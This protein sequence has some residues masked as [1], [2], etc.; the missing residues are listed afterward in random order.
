M[1]AIARLAA[2][3]L[4]APVAVLA[5]AEGTNAPEIASNRVDGNGRNGDCYECSVSGNGQVVVFRSNTDNLVPM[6]NE[7][8]LDRI[9]LGDLGAGTMALVSQSAGIQFN[10]G[11]YNPQVSSNGRFVLFQTYTAGLVEP[12]N[13]GTSDLYLLDRKKGTLRVVSLDGDGNVGNSDSFMDGAALSANG[14]FVAFYSTSSNFVDGVGNGN[15]QAFLLDVK[16]GRISLASRNDAGEPADNGVQRVSISAN[17][18]WLSFVSDASNLGVMN[19]NSDNQIFAYDA[20]RKRTTLASRNLMGFVGNQSS[21]SSVIANNGV[22]AFLSYASDIGSGNMDDG[23]QDAFVF[24]P[25]KGGSITAIS[26][27]TGG[28]DAQGSANGV[29]ISQNGK[30]V[31]FST[32]QNLVA[33]DPNENYDVYAA[34]LPFVAP[35]LISR[36]TMDFAGNGDSYVNSSGL[37][38]NGKWLVY[39]TFAND[40][41]DGDLNGGSDVVVVDPRR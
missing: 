39:S 1:S 30:L 8:N 19:G 16:T 10:S 23:D 21:D 26:R 33:A 27:N 31:V 22:T 13:T 29:T 9:F 38:G 5:L 25:R 7:G 35:R 4:V 34:D 17:G 40:I 20:K 12:D 6:L 3:V 15:Y 32:S 37:A 14:R 18:R 36:A 2:A 28:S 41:A 24:D 11:S